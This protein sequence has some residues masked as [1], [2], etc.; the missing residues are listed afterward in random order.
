MI[1]QLY[2]AYLLLLLN[3]VANKRY[4]KLL[5]VYIDQ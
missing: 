2:N 4:R 1:N 3:L 5:A